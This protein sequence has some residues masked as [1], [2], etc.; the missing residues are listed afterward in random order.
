MSNYFEIKKKLEENKKFCNKCHDMLFNTPK[1]QS[2]KNI[3]VFLNYLEKNKNNNNNNYFNEDNYKIPINYNN[4]SND[5]SGVKVIGHNNYNQSRGN[6]NINSNISYS[7]S[8][9]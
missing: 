6:F 8:V 7:V 4:R 2:D 5:M 9:L 3:E 1:E